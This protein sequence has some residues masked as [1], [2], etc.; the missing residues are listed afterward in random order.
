M[1][2]CTLYVTQHARHTCTCKNGKHCYTEIETADDAH[3]H[4]IIR[5]VPLYSSD[6]PTTLTSDQWYC[7]YTH[8]LY[9]STAMVSGACRV[10]DSQ[11]SMIVHVPLLHV[12]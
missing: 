2:Q 4:A 8:C 9:C 5:D 11:K 3:F 6:V 12:Q 10:I 7:V 1:S